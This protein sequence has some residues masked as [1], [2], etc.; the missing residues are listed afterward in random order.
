M[1]RSTLALALL[2]AAAPLRAADRPNF[3]FLFA[4]DQRYDAVG[5]VQREQGDRGRFGIN[6]WLDV[7]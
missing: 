3:V 2:A 4:D 5:A 7:T 6:L 1:T